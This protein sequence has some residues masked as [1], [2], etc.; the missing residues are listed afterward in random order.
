MLIG[1]YIYVFSALFLC[2]QLMLVQAI[3]RDE[4]RRERR[5]QR[6]QG[7][8]AEEEDYVVERP[9]GG[10]GSF[11]RDER[12]R[13]K[14]ERRQDKLERR[15]ERREER[16]RQRGDNQLNH[17]TDVTVL[18]PDTG[19]PKVIPGLHSEM[20]QA[21]NH[22]STGIGKPSR[23]RGKL[24]TH[25]QGRPSAHEETNEQK[26]YGR[27]KQPSGPIDLQW[28]AANMSSLW[29]VVRNLQHHMTNRHQKVRGPNGRRG[30][31]ETTGEE[32][33]G[34]DDACRGEEDSSVCSSHGVCDCGNCD[35]NPGFYGTY[36][37]CNDHSCPAYNGMACGGPSRG[38]CRCSDCVCRPGY[39][40]DACECST[41]TSSCHKDSEDQL[42]SN[43]GTCECGTCKCNDGYQGLY[44]EDNVYDAGVCERLKPCVLC[45]AW[46]KEIPQCVECQVTLSMVDSLEPGM[47]TCVMVSKGCLLQYSYNAE[48]GGAYSVQVPKNMTCSSI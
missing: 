16:R 14:D 45:K 2:I 5:R 37:Q 11:T 12:R 24:G 34:G 38:Q 42:C 39:V 15:E 3:D 6:L 1:Q 21:S 47:K 13:S 48:P 27:Q 19:S 31:P 20:G 33:P 41:D 18:G 23:H 17:G 10:G 40:G 30:Q 36:C 25:G 29:H 26:I 32:C 4:R 22:I 7:G 9:G 8:V 43:Q 35:C 44:C 28:L 46:N